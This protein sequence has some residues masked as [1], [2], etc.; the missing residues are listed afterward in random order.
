[1]TSHQAQI[2][3]VELERRLMDAI[4]RIKRLEK[5]GNALVKE[6]IWNSKKPGMELHPAHLEWLKAKDAR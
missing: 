3:V 1:M 5:A 2:N 6:F 4:A